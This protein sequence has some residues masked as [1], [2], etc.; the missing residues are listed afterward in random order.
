MCVYLLLTVN[1]SKWESGSEVINQGFLALRVLFFSPLMFIPSERGIFSI[2]KNAGDRKGQVASQ[3][4][5]L[6]KLSGE[7]F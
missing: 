3:E 6:P 2:K 4:V 1:M 7:H 5:L